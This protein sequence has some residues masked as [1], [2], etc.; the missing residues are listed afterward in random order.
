MVIINNSSS[1]IVI[2]RVCAGDSGHTGIRPAGLPA[3]RSHAP[4][5][6]EMTDQPLA[7]PYRTTSRLSLRTPLVRHPHHPVAH[8]EAQSRHE[9]RRARP[10]PVNE[11]AHRRGEHILRQDGRSRERAQLRSREVQGRAEGCRKEGE[12]EDG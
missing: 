4:V 7:L 9:R 3:T 12:G 11:R 1:A 5:Q 10:A 8:R 6:L 2:L